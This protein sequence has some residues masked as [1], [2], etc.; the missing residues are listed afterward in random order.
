MECQCLV[1]KPYP[2]TNPDLLDV[3][4]YD[5]DCPVHGWR[6][7]YYGKILSLEEYQKIDERNAIREGYK[8]FYNDNKKN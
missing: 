2:E 7:D 3:A 5:I 4:A 6:W 8:V 1:Y